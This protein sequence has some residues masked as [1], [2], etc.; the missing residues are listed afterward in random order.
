M[1]SIGKIKIRRDDQVQV[2]A[3]RDR[4]KKGRVLSVDR[5][6]GRVVV[7]GL[8]MVKKA[9]KKKKQTDRGGIIEIEAA[10]QVSNV[11]IVCRKCGPTRIGYKLAEGSKVRVC[12]KCGE[13]L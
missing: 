7:E 11:M 5:E 6:K 1:E 8:N 3:G 4:G 10:L 12:R 9:M 13:A 2:V